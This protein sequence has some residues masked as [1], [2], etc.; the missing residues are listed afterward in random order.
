[1]S[2]EYRIGQA[3]SA[4]QVQAIQAAIELELELQPGPD[5]TIVVLEGAR[6]SRDAALEQ[7]ATAL[8]TLGIDAPIEEL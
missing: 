4:E 7:L 5:E 6:S 1:M 8:E 3:L 2:H